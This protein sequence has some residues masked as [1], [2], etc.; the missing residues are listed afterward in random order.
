VTDYPFAISLLADQDRSLFSCGA[1]PLDI[2]LRQHASQDMKRRIAACFVAVEAASGTIAGFYT[3]SACHIGLSGLDADWQR[4]LPRYPTVPAVRLGRLAIDTRFQG[5]KLGAA[6][7]ANA[8]AR[9]IR[10]DIAAH[11]MMVDA[12]DAKAAAFYLH[13]GF[14]PDPVE[15]L[16]LYAPLA[17]LA[18]SLGLDQK[19]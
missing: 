8:V 3:L 7:L 6:L 13:H 18:A 16:R 4:K 17:R 9:A 11:M 10:S 19:T 1:A 14:R 5:Q 12:K 15:P 2:Y